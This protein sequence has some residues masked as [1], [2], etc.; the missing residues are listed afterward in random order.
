MCAR[1]QLCLVALAAAFAASGVQGWSFDVLDDAPFASAAPSPRAAVCAAIKDRVDCSSGVGSK[2]GGV[3]PLTASEC[4]VRGWWWGT[5]IFRGWALGSLT[6]PFHGPVVC[7]C[8]VRAQARGCCWAQTTDFRPACFY[9]SEGVAAHTIHMINS[10]H[11]DAR[12]TRHAPPSRTL[13]PS[14]LPRPW[15]LA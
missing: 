15:L 8:S 5:R 6:L 3:A 10:N 11:F 1:P 2:G 7:V 12:G 4:E 9:D 13:F 14:L